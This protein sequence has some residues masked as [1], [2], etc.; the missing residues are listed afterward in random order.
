MIKTITNNNIKIEYILE[1]K[2]VK[3]I[4]MRIKSDGKVYVSASPR[5][6][7]KVIDEFVISKHEFINNAINKF[8]EAAK[9]PKIQYY[10]ENEV[11]EL[12]LRLCDEVYPYFESK[13]IK[14]PVIKFRQ[15]KSKWGSCHTTKGILTF[16][17]NLMYAPEECIR[18]VVLHEFT[19]FIKADHSKEFYAELS[20]VCPEW[21]TL[22]KKLNNHGE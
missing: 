18:Y 3:N 5:V 21:K 15:M 10:T 11:K 12:I 2:R 14:Y 17:L 4:N 7:Q 1:R 20:K 13:G 19:H 9:Q 8:A 22:R 6:P 16:S